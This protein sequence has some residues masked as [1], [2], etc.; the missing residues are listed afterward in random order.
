MQILI[1]FPNTIINT[2]PIPSFSIKKGEILFIHIPTKYDVNVFNKKSNIPNL[3]IQIESEWVKFQIMRYSNAALDEINKYLPYL[4]QF[5]SSLHSY[6]QLTKKNIAT[7]SG[8][9]IRLINLFYLLHVKKSPFIEINVA[10]LAPESIV[11]LLDFSMD[12]HS[13]KDKQGTIVIVD[14][15]KKNLENPTF[16][17]PN[18][19]ILIKQLYINENSCISPPFR[20]KL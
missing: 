10:G 9:D 18:N 19:L 14:S 5:S 3:D 6:K 12:I 8:W 11:H 1:N 13:S 7:L 4:Q 20:L 16:I 17:T 15:N 2:L